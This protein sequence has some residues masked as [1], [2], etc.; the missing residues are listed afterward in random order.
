MIKQTVRMESGGQKQLVA[1]ARAVIKNPHLILSDEPT[2]ALDTESAMTLLDRFVAM[3]EEHG[4]TILMVTHDSNAA[5]FARRVLFIRDG[6]LFHEISRGSDSR[7][8][9]FDKII[10]IISLLGGMTDTSRLEAGA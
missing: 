6:K 7:R 8:E 9:F 5:S 4:A 10:G 3:N 2:G 1:S